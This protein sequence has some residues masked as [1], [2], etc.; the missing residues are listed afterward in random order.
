[1]T[2][3]DNLRLTD[4]I[5]AYD[6]GKTLSNPEICSLLSKLRN[7]KVRNISDVKI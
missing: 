4:L 1:M 5:R 2:E 3:E 6:A 7:T